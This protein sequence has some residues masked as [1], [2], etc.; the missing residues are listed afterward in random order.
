MLHP[1]FKNDIDHAKIGPQP[2][3]IRTETSRIPFRVLRDAPNTL[4]PKSPQR[5][6]SLTIAETNSKVIIDKSNDLDYKVELIFPIAR[7]E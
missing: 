7:T 5:S 6:A 1:Q 4:S 2:Q 3:L